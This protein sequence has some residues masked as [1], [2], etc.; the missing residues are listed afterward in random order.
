VNMLGGAVHHSGTCQV[1]FDFDSEIPRA[2]TASVKYDGAAAFFG[3]AEIIP[4]WVADMDFAVPEAITRALIERATHPI[5]G[6]TLCPDSMVEALMSWMK[7]R[8]GWE[9]ERS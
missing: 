4:M 9:I 8:H 2:G 7:R 6:Y 3:S 1:S 5:Y